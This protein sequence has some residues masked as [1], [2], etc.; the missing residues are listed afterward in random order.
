[1]QKEKKYF[2][3]YK[4]PLVSV[5]NLVENQVAS[6]KWLI[7]EGIKE[8]FDEFSPIQDYSGKKFELEFTSFETIRQAPILV[9]CLSSY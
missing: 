9:I 5:P 1:M 6:F 3:R 4:E 8:I 2:S 7:A